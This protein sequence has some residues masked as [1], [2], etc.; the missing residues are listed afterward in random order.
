VTAAWCFFLDLME[1]RD[2][3]ADVRNMLVVVDHAL[4]SEAIIEHAKG[5]GNGHAHR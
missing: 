5:K 1:K 3:P 2:P 4:L